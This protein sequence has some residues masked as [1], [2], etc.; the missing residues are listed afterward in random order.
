M[1]ETKDP[2][3]VLQRIIDE[4]PGADPSVWR[5]Q[6]LREVM[7]DPDLQRAVVDKVLTD[8]FDDLRQSRH[9]VIRRCRRSRQQW[10]YIW[11]VSQRQHLPPTCSGD[12]WQPWTTARRSQEHA[13]AAFDWHQRLFGARRRA[14]HRKDPLSALA[15]PGPET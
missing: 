1:S 3:A 2:H 8:M 13:E 7:D 12:S 14:A 4:N 9:R 6:S 10:G 15:P 11:R 5:A